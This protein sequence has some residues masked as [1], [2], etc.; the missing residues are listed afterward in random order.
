MTTKTL[1]SAA[2]TQLELLRAFLFA[3]ER[4]GTENLNLGDY[5]NNPELQDEIARL[6]I[7]GP[8]DIHT[9]V[10]EMEI[11]WSISLWHMLPSNNRDRL[12]EYG[13]KTIFGVRST[14]LSEPEPRSEGKTNNIYTFVQSPNIP[15]SGLD[16][17]LIE[18]F[19]KDGLYSVDES[20]L[21]VFGRKYFPFDNFEL[22]ATGSHTPSGSFPAFTRNSLSW[23]GFADHEHLPRNSFILFRTAR[24]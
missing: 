6:I 4:N 19:E 5:I 24:L 17:Y 13:K 23:H 2:G 20:E 10:F 1:V 11:D 3:L 12:M 15:R 21:F 22:L 14:P 18:R 7:G 16:Q 9:Q 8:W